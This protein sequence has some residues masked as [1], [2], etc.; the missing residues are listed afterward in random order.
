MHASE[1]LY[2]NN[3]RSNCMKKYSMADHFSSIII[4]C[5]FIKKYEHKCEL[6]LTVT[7]KQ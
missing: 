3:I 2:L 6:V 5:S 7:L 4:H 1:C